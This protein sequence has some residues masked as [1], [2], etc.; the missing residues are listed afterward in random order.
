M[1]S[2]SG[3]SRWHVSAPCRCCPGPLPPEW[4]R[5]SL[6]LS[7][8]AAPSSK[9][10]AR[11]WVSLGQGHKQPQSLQRARDRL[12]GHGRDEEARA[13]GEANCLPNHISFKS[14]AALCI[15]QHCQLTPQVRKL[16]LREVN[17]TVQGHTVSRGQTESKNGL[18]KL[19]GLKMLRHNQRP[20]FV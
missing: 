1:S 11:F 8:G 19:Q 6:D 10:S 3:D 18:A 14:Q 16:R 7:S 20:R 9:G 13:G 4:L 5:T 12:R 2:L 15:K 17:S